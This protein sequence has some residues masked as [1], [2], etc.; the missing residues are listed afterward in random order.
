MGS[1]LLATHNWKL[2]NIVASHSQT[3]KTKMIVC[4]TLYT[5]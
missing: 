4:L 3:H 2:K 1:C 5:V